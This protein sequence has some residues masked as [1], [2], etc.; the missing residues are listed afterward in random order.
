MTSVAQALATR[1]PHIRFCRHWEIRPEVHFQ[2]GQCQAIISAICEMPLLPKRYRELLSVS[3]MKGAQATTAIEGNTL[4]D[5]EVEKVAAGESLAPSKE[6]QERE[7]RNVLNAM[8]Q[9]LKDVVAEGRTGLIAVPL[10]WKL[11]K[12][13]GRELGDHFDAVP[14]EFRKDERIVGPYKCPRAADVP[15]L[16]ARLCD[17]LQEEFQFAQ[18]RQTFAAA[19]V[20]AIVTHVYLEWIHPFGDGNGRTGRLL[21]FYI[22][23]RA[24]NPDIASHILSNFYNQTRPEYY[25]QLDKA[26]EARDLG[27]FIAY[28]VQGYRDGLQESLRT[29]QQSQFEMAWQMLIYQRFADVGYKKKNVFKRRR[30]LMLSFPLTGEV[31]FDAIPVLTTRLARAYASLTDRT[32]LRDVQF[33]VAMDLVRRN[34]DTGRFLAHTGLLRNQMP[35]RA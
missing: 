30:S 19:V 12:A 22:L 35:R 33:L 9:I 20:Q 27:A 14:G 32:L 6:Y 7:V 5:I 18:G 24:G 10:I 34:P 26:R 16:A 21:E 28:A 2:L 23:L 3:L 8:N 25:R 4:T 31:P 15:A 29:I 17:W 13:V 11:H 1:Y